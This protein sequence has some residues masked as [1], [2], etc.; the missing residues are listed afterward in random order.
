[1]NY[2]LEDNDGIRTLLP[3][4]SR[5]VVEDVE[6]NRT[7]QQAPGS[8]KVW[9]SGD[10][11]P[12]VR[13]VTVTVDVHGKS[14]LHVNEQIATLVDAARTAVRLGRLRYLS[15]LTLLRVSEVTYRAARTVGNVQ[16]RF[17][18]LDP[19]WHE[20]DNDGSRRLNE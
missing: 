14:E 12:R 15:I 13:Y 20:A 4:T 5:V 18:L 1:M 6:Y 11:A 17:A 16:L 8:G 19:Y 3:R 10:G 9:V 2:F 7:I